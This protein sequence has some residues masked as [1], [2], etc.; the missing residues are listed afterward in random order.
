MATQTRATAPQTYNRTNQ[1]ITYL[2][3]SAAPKLEPTPQ[4]KPQKEVER[5]QAPQKKQNVQARPYPVNMPL[6][7]LSILAFVALG[8]MM[9]QYIRLNS[10][11]TVLSTANTKLERQISDLRAENDEYYSRIMNSVDLEKVREVAI[12]DLGMVYASEGQVITYVSQMDDYVEQ[13][14]VI[15]D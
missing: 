15:K 13:S 4:R 9:I 5:R 7:I 1:K 11:I 3:G 2:Y 10:D 6:L 12:M 8:V 14:R